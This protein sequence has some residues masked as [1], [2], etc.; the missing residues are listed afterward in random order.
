MMGDRGNVMG[1]PLANILHKV[2]AETAL[3]LLL[4]LIIWSLFGDDYVVN[5]AFLKTGRGNFDELSLFLQLLDAVTATIAH[6][7]FQ[8]TDK[9]RYHGGQRT[10]VRDPS[11]YS[12]RNQF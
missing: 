4:D 5:V 3:T 11:L 10:F 2:S 9:L 6:A 12:L 8:A 7:G 1:L